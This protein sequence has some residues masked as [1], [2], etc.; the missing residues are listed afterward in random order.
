MPVIAA[1]RTTASTVTLDGAGDT[2]LAMF[3]T[4][5][6]WQSAA[7]RGDGPD[8][9][10]IRSGAGNK[11]KE[12]A[13]VCRTCPAIG[14][15]LQ[16]AFGEHPDHR[17]VGPFRIVPSRSWPALRQIV[18]EWQPQTGDDWGQLAAWVV[19]SDIEM[20]KRGRPAA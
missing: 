17:R 12:L 9:W 13:A 10:V 15:C 20:P 8:K 5:A 18:R 14:A 16:D 6:W 19:D 2:E 4:P 3:D 7:C 11:V 1:P